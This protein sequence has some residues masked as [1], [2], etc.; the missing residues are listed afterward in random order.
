MYFSPII[1]TYITAYLKRVEFYGTV[2]EAQAWRYKNCVLNLTPLCHAEQIMWF[3]LHSSLKIK[4]KMRKLIIGQEA[5]CLA[6]SKVQYMLNV[7]M[8][9]ILSRNNSLIIHPLAF[10][11]TLHVQLLEVKIN[12]RIL[13]SE[14]DS[15]L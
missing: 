1:M 3:L 15:N 14:D 2:C 4:G 8:I 5:H 11:C 9:L 12:F 6:D 13:L 7:I 10:L